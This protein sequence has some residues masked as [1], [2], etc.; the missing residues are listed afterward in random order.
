MA[1]GE[2]VSLQMKAG[3]L[4]VEVVGLQRNVFC[5]WH[6]LLGFGLLLES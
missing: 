2:Y 6:S 5:F 4:G 3:I 1:G